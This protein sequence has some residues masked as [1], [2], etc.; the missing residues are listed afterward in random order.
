M[1]VLLRQ[2]YSYT[3]QDS[4]PHKPIFLGTSE[5]EKNKEALQPEAAV[6]EAVIRLRSGSGSAYWWVFVRLVC[7]CTHA[8][9]KSVLIHCT[10]NGSFCLHLFQG[11][12]RSILVL[13]DL[14]GVCV[15]VCMVLV[16]LLLCVCVR[17]TAGLPGPVSTSSSHSLWHETKPVRL[18][19]HA[20]LHPVLQ[21]GCLHFHCLHWLF[22]RLFLLW[23]QVLLFSNIFTALTTLCP[24]F[25]S[26][27]L[28]Y[29]WF[30]PLSTGGD[31]RADY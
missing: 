14:V 15:C 9:A 29:F 25:T 20:A 17:W 8:W 23:L 28:M 27:C 11:S 4:C 22:V 1:A 3:W 2:L 13:T 12:A 31:Q 24:S 21:S 30:P 6:K 10:C 18:S 5:G 7:L 19:T 16:R 26:F